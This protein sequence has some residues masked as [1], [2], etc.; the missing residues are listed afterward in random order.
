MIRS[1]SNHPPINKLYE[2]LVTAVGILKEIE[3]E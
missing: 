2:R 1:Y 3:L